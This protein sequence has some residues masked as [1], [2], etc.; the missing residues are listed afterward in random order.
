MAQAAKEASDA[1]LQRDAT[2]SQERLQL[3][4]LIQSM[5][6]PASSLHSPGQ[7]AQQLFSSPASA[8]STTTSSVV[9]LPPELVALMKRR[10]ED[11]S[12]VFSSWAP[13][14]E[15]FSDSQAATLRNLL[16]EYRWLKG[17]RQASHLRQALRV[18]ADNFAAHHTKT[19]GLHMA[20]ITAALRTAGATVTPSHA[21]ELQAMLGIAATGQGTVDWPR[22][23]I[24][25]T[26]VLATKSL[27]LGTF[28]RLRIARCTLPDDESCGTAALANLP[29]R[30]QQQQRR[31]PNEHGS[32]N[33]H[34]TRIPNPS[35]KEKLCHMCGLPGWTK[36]HK[37]KDA[38]IL[39]FAKSP[40]SKR[41]FR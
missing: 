11:E 7:V 29:I 28:E 24:A 16:P 20:E 18:V 4:S 34:D 31:S 27:P 5:S 35:A 2:A 6:S 22:V 13:R 39:A 32:N 3:M 17:D 21:A 10:E 1:Q 26:I 12:K 19:H 40:A 41:G 36:E 15:H 23:S 37:C 8:V 25:E 14:A 9:Q 38:D 33:T 30:Q